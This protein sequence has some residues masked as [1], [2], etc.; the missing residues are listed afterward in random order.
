M[1][2]T[3]T[4]LPLSGQ[5]RS[6]R[7]EAVVDYTVGSELVTFSPDARPEA[8]AGTVVRRWYVA[9]ASGQIVVRYLLTEQEAEER[10]M[11]LRVD[12]FLSVPA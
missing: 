11:G 7:G 3:G 10:L 5:V 6:V 12:A 9:D 1:S 4:N 2:Y 8:L